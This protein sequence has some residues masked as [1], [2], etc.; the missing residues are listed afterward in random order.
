M[1][2][3]NALKGLIVKEG[4]SLRRTTMD[5]QIDRASLQRS[6]NEGANPEWKTIEKV[7][8]YLGYEIALV[9]KESI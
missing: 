4:R 9:R 5:L 6:L 2:I 3:G 8:N 7:L 1:D